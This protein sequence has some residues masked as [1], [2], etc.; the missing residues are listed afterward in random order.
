MRIP[1]SH[2]FAVW[3]YFVSF[4]VAKQQIYLF[5]VLVQTYPLTVGF[6]TEAEVFM[7]FMN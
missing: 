2:L 7:G 5:S 4:Y 1:I 3:K 6:L